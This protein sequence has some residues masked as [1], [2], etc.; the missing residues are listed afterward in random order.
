MA[1]TLIEMFANFNET[2]KYVP[3][4]WVLSV[5]LFYG[6]YFLAN[7]IVYA[8]IYA[9]IGSSL[10]TVDDYVI[11]LIM[12]G[13]VLVALYFLGSCYALYIC[14][15]P[16]VLAWIFCI[17]SALGLILNLLTIPPGL[18]LERSSL[19][20]LGYFLISTVSITLILV[21]FDWRNSIGASS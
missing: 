9:I 7:K 3:L 17:L 16:R 11:Y 12:I 4:K 20:N 10:Q 14:P 2:K 1:T 19:A 18:L 21:K 8:L 5:V 6:Y 15:K 13:A